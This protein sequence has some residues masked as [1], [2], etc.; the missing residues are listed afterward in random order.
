MAYERVN[1]ENLPSTKTPVNADN[2]NK[3]N[4]GIAEIDNKVTTLDNIVTGSGTVNS[5]YVSAAE[6]NYY[7]K[8]GKVVSYNFTITIKGTW[9]NTTQFIS[10]LPKAKKNSRFVGIGNDGLVYRFAIDTNGNILNQYSKT[11]PTSGILLEG[12]IT[13]ITSE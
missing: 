11:T 5:T 1:W 2:L 12:Q 9:T 4:E 13:Y 8:W 3:M 6:Y 10:G 7:V